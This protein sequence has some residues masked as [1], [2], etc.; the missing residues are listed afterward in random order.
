MNYRDNN[1]LWAFAGVALST[2]VVLGALL[3]VWLMP[4]DPA[5]AAAQDAQNAAKPSTITVVGTGSI[6]VK[7]DILRMTVGVS[8]QEDTVLAAQGTVDSALAAIYA[9]LKEAGVAETDYKTAQYSVEP[10]MNYNDQKNGQGVLTG[11]RVVHMLEITFRNIDGAP[12]IVDGLVKAGANTIYGTSFG[13]NDAESVGQRAHEE[14]VKDAQ[15]RAERLAALSN[16]TLGKIVSVSES[17]NGP[18]P[19]YSKEVG[20]GAGGASFAPGTQAIQTS[21][22]VTYEATPIK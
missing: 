7:P 10:V 12:A 6:A 14:A 16:M 18:Y 5:P 3:V 4:R 19:V 15:K 2:L 22:V 11:F 17:N 20:M 13:F 9:R 8:A 1:R 21:L